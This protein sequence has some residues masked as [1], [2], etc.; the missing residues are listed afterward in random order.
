MV[1]FR[2]LDA[3]YR[4]PRQNNEDRNT[5]QGQRETDQHRQPE[6]ASGGSHGEPDRCDEAKNKNP[7]HRP[8]PQLFNERRN[9]V[10]GLVLGDRPRS[11]SRRHLELGND[12]RPVRSGGGTDLT[13]RLLAN[14]P[15]RE[16][17]VV[18][19]IDVVGLDT[20]STG[21][22]LGIGAAAV[23]VGHHRGLDRLR[24]L[25][26]PVRRDL[27]GRRTRRR[28]RPEGPIDMFAQ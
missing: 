4:L 21:R 1:G 12:R 20:A 5:D 28:G 11:T 26:P 9:R 25:L 7:S 27:D 3:L 8:G 23:R 13:G 22:A 2:V 6:R 24:K 19:C 15:R 16:A 14:L 18:A 10:V 17:E